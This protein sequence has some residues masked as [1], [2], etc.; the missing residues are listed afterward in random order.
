MSGT[1]A[2]LLI[3][4]SE[5]QD[6]TFTRL[7]TPAEDVEALQRVLDDPE[8][9]G[10]TSQPLLNKSSEEIRKQIDEFF[11]NRKSDDFLLLYF[12]CHGELDLRDQ[13]YF[14]ATDTTKNCRTRRESRR[15]GSRSR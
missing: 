11:S 15:D 14:V 3:G 10:F 2:A 4:C 8:I 9:G 5:Y 7:R 1:R 6:P 12:S 13:L